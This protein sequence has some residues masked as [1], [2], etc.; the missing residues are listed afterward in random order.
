MYTLLVVDDEMFTRKGI[1][2]KVPTEPDGISE[3]LEA[4]DGKEGL[5]I[6]QYSPVDIVL[7]DVR[8]PR[9]DGI[10]MCQEIRRLYPDCVIIFLSGYSDKE[11]L[12]S[13]I[14]MQALQYIDK[15]VDTGALQEALSQAVSYCN[16]IRYSRKFVR[17]ANRK[18][19]ARLLLSSPPSNGQLAVALSESGHTYEDFRDSLTVIFQFLPGP[20]ASDEKLGFHDTLE[21]CQEMISEIIRNK[22]LPFLKIKRFRKYFPLTVS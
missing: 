19:L 11:Y 16:E 20:D 1:I 10:K 12:R 22:H 4:R 3:V 8:M 5:A 2:K 14:S 6:A 7:S 18:R 17:E 9:M 21:Q 15:P 13:A